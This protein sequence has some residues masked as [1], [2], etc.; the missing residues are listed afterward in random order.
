MQLRCK[1]CGDVQ[2]VTVADE[3]DDDART[4]SIRQT[5]RT[6]HV[7]RCGEGA[8]SLDTAP[9]GVEPIDGEAW[10][11]YLAA[12][13]PPEGVTVGGDGMFG[14]TIVRD[15]VE[16]SVRVC[17]DCWKTMPRYVDYPQGLISPESDGAG[18]AVAK[19]R[20]L[21]VETEDKDRGMSLEHIRKAVCVPCYLAAF[22]RVY[23]GAK[24]PRLST[25]VIGDEPEVVV[26]D[27][28]GIFVPGP[29]PVPV[30]E[31]VTQ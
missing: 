31:T 26:P 8:V 22:S 7:G 5:F 27:V 6:L 19:M 2:P 28:P 16:Q 18:G 10:N 25:D 15:G 12:V 20:P 23:V 17:E 24:L 29:K 14:R 11:K 4:R 3:A 21:L 1:I 30:D 9:P 13:K